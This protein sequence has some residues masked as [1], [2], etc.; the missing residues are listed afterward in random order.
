MLVAYDFPTAMAPGERRQVRVTMR[1]T[2][3]ASPAND[4]TSDY[5]LRRSGTESFEW[6]YWPLFSNIAVGSTNEFVFTITAPRV[7]GVYTFSARMWSAV[8]NQAGYFGE[9]LSIPNIVVST[10]TQ[11]M[12]RCALVASN[13]PGRMGTLQ[14][15]TAQITVQNTGTAAWP[16]DGT[17]CFRSR[18]ETQPGNDPQLWGPNVCPAITGPVAPGA[19]TTLTFDVTAPATA[20]TWAFR[21]QMQTG[22]IDIFDTLNFCISQGIAIDPAPVFRD[23]QIIAQSFPTTLAPNEPRIVNVRMRNLGSETWTPVDHGLGSQATP[24][25]LF[26]TIVSNVGAPTP[27]NADHDFSFVIRAP[28]PGSYTQSWRMQRLTSPAPGPFGALLSVPLV[29]DPAATPEYRAQLVS[30]SI[31]ARVIAGSTQTFTVTMRN[32]GPGAWDDGRF[33]LL[34]Q[35]SPGNLWGVTAQPL[36]PGEIV[37]PSTDRTF[38]FGVTAPST[39]GVYD[40]RWV[41]GLAGYPLAASQEALATV[42]V[43]ACGN[44]LLDP[45]ESCDDG[46]SDDLDGCDSLCRGTVLDLQADLPARTLIGSSGI[47]Q[48]ANVAIGD[49]TG[50]GVNEVV[51]G[52]MAHV[53]PVGQRSRS[54]A[55]R[56][57]VFLGGPSFFD[58][59]RT[60]VPANATLELWGANNE[61]R[62]GGSLMGGI[63]V[64]DVT[65][66]GVGDLIVSSNHADG[67]GELRTDCGEVFVIAGGPGLVG[68]G[69]IDT[70]LVPPSP[71]ITARIIGPVPGAG[72]V[73]VTAGDLTGDGIADLVLGSQADSTGGAGAGRVIVVPGG[74]GLSGVID[75]AEGTFADVFAGP[76]DGLGRIA[77]VGDISGDGAA[78]LLLGTALHD[79]S[80]ANNG[81]AVWAIFG[82]IS[83][84]HQLAA[85]DYDAAWF[86]G[87]NERYGSTLGIANVSGDGENEIIVGAPQTRDSGL[88]QVGSVDV[89]STPIAAGARFDV[90]S[91][92]MPAARISA[93]SYGDNTGRALSFGDMNGDGYAELPIVMSAA[94]GPLDLRNNCGELG[95]VL[96][97]AVLPAVRELGVN[98]PVF[99]LLGAA[100]LNYLGNHPNNLAIGDIDGDGLADLCA[101][102]PNGGSDASINAPG[103]IDCI[104]SPF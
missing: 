87:T 17:T 78:D 69:V 95:I 27:T 2:G 48:L 93:P 30:Q 10:A 26:G 86:G 62:L 98:P 47:K 29:V 15:F 8:P 35:S 3:L 13:L 21:R 71:L 96:G 58:G 33:A 75:L 46:N 70:A 81:G 51:A 100:E 104:R 99:Q 56:V 4:W 83:G 24:N 77:A 16:A 59:T 55:G 72:L 84:P 41:I 97:G 25:D 101:G 22:A 66:D 43:T 103:R 6:N 44:A 67:A 32:V 31:P 53:Y 18:D 49:L 68:A 64:S 74:A 12:W 65:G 73:I 20:G 5:V 34:S 28:A 94:D 91:V 63:V 61:D 85:G 89:W 1:N 39:P 92:V 38:S 102:S 88:I 57:H 37:G 52:E 11:P 45:G 60:Q 9:E 50:D 40:S 23:A 14:P 82:P 42:E 36:N 54:R 76:G 19:T 79:P 80:G 90:G 7:A